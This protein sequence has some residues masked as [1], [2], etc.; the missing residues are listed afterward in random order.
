MW[1]WIR[2]SVNFEHEEAKNRRIKIFGS[3]LLRVF[4][5]MALALVIGA[6]PAPNTASANVGPPIPKLWLTFEDADGQPITPTAVQVL[7][8]EDEGCAAPTLLAATG[9]CNT[10]PCIGTPPK[11]LAQAECKAQHCLLGFAPSFPP[12]IK[13][14]A[15]FDQSILSSLVIDT[16]D[17]VLN[18]S[19][20]EP[21]GLRVV[22][23]DRLTATP[24]PRVPNFDPSQNFGPAFL[25]TLITEV[26][27]GLAFLFA[28]K[29][30]PLPLLLLIGLMQAL[31]FPVVWFFFP[32]LQA[33]QLPNN[34]LLG[35]LL[36]GI[37]I[38]FGVLLVWVRRAPQ[39]KP[40]VFSI[41]A[42]VAAVP[43]SIV[44]LFFGLLITSYGNNQFATPAGLPYPVML[45][46]A[47]A[48]AVLYEA[49][50]I[51]LLSNRSLT[52]KQSALMSLVAN[53]VS[54]GL[55]LLLFPISPSLS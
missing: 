50:L 13:L 51:Y 7:G 43:A 18:F 39:G 52:F 30:P 1:C 54:F 31:S 46:G 40:R 36:L 21:T 26:L 34:R 19:Y 42:L 10:T 2:R 25:L 8:C 11:N 6:S 29:K 17:L 28:F 55:G 20:S 53:A 9:T 33:W 49:V 5:L 27:V 48:F 4:M 41:L 3:S 14:V 15:Q 47:E 44:C 22:V 16:R 32:A 45:M 38:V 12:H 37:A 23:S 35:V 24:D